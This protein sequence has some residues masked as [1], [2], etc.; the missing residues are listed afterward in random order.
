MSTVAIIIPVLNEAAYIK[1]HGMLFQ[2]LDAEILFVDGGSQ[3]QT[4]ILLQKHGLNVIVSEQGR[5][6]QMNQGAEHTEADIL[7]FLHVD[8]EF[9][10]QHLQHI[11]QAM[12]DEQVVS[13]RFDVRL[14]G[15][16]WMFRVIETMIN[17]RS[18][19]TRISTGDQVIFVRRTVFESLGGFSVLP[20]MED[21]VLSRLLKTQGDIAC[22]KDTVLTSSR[23]WEECGIFSTILLMWRL[24]FLFFIGVPA[25]KLYESYV[26]KR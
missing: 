25:Q 22:L 14:S 20:I 24:R 23:R 13:G 9:D 17:W 12:L 6:L 3:D 8:T 4:G 15:E 2:N 18:R 16:H 11:Q 1:T 10:A 21:I 7:V 26:L 5:A 19:V